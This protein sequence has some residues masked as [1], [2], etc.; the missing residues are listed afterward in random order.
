M[1]EEAGHYRAT[2]PGNYTGSP[3]PLEYYFEVRLA[4]DTAFLYPGLG[5][6]LTSQPYFVAFANRGRPASG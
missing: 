3:Y 1:N 2:I 4:P 6:D 5:K